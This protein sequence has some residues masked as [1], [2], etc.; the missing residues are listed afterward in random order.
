MNHKNELI[1]LLDSIITCGESMAK[2]GR[3]LK[4]VLPETAEAIPQESKDE[5]ASETK[6]TPAK[7]PEQT[8]SPAVPVYTFTEIRKAFSA[9]SHAGFTEQIRELI[10]KYGADRLSGVKEEDYPAL[11]TD[12]EVIG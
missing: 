11:M 1:E 10:S 4:E 5:A 9:K 8:E 2:I 3:L 6:S 7:L 12:L